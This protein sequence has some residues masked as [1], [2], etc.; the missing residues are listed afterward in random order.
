[1]EEAVIAAQTGVVMPESSKNLNA[2][3]RERIRMK[4]MKTKVSWA[5]PLLETQIPPSWPDPS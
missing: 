5:R 4:V 3:I 1:M 2:S